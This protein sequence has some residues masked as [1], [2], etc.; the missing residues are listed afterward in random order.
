MSHQ[1]ELSERVKAMFASKYFNNSPDARELESG[2][3]LV[4]FDIQ[5][6]TND[7]NRLLNVTLQSRCKNNGI[8]S[9]TILKIN[10]PSHAF[11]R[12]V[13]LIT[14][15][16]G[17]KT[18][19]CFEFDYRDGEIAVRNFLQCSDYIPSTATLYTMMGNA[20]S[21]LMEY[22]DRLIEAIGVDANT[23]ETCDMSGSLD[24]LDEVL[25]GNEKYQSLLIDLIKRD[26]D[27]FYHHRLK[28]AANDGNVL[29]QMLLKKCMP[30]QSDFER[31]LIAAKEGDIDAQYYVGICYQTGKD[32]A[33]VDPHQAKHWLEYAANAGSADALYYLGLRIFAEDEYYGSEE[34]GVRY[35]TSAAQKG[36]ATAQYF[37]GNF[38]WDGD[39]VHQNQDQAVMWYEKAAQQNNADAQFKLGLIYQSDDYSYTDAKKA[40]FWL[41]RAAEQGNVMAQ[42][43]I[44]VNYLVGNGVEENTQK[45]QYWLEK[46]ALQGDEKAISTLRQYCA[47]SSVLAEID[48]KSQPQPT[49]QA[50]PSSTSTSSK[51]SGGCYIATCVYGSYDCPQVWTLRRYRDLVLAESVLGRL[52]IRFYYAVSPR[53][54]KAF[55]GCS[56]IRNI[57]K[58]FLDKM[59]VDLNEKGYQDTPYE[60]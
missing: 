3:I 4:S 38:Y 29:A 51:S 12:V 19:S 42:K 35:L 14:Q 33:P 30:A 49:R 27:S 18:F 1:Y 25:N 21:K 31:A 36:N 46:A 22:G 5:L 11:K 8:V 41:E 17:S 43:Q 48:R 34:D 28:E 24:V 45:F 50:T 26:P 47:G 57:W 44:A 59:V 7:D 52:F 32:N 15:I 60:D 53:L 23:L 16:N 9:R 56:S 6:V 13:D 54:V 20:T 2:D 39:H 37:L 10:A 40:A 55:G 58:V